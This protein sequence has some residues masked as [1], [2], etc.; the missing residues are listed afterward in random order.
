MGK[1]QSTGFRVTDRDLEIVRWLGRVRLASVEH[2]RLRFGM[3][4][5]KA[6]ER[7]A[8][9]VARGL[10]VRERHVPGHGVYV[11]TREGLRVAGLAMAPARVSL[12]ALAHDLACAEVVARIEAGLPAARLLTERQLRAHVHHTG[13]DSFR[14][15]VRQ[16]GRRDARHWP[17]L[18]LLTGSREPGWL[19]IEV[20]L[21]RKGARRLEAILD[22]YW[23]AAHHDTPHQVWGVL[24][25]VPDNNDRRRLAA[26]AER[27]GL[28]E[29]HSPVLFA[30]HT[31]DRHDEIA[32]TVLTLW[33]RKRTAD[34][35][36]RAEAAERERQQHELAA[37]QA[38]ERALTEDGIQRQRQRQEQLQA[39]EEAQR[40]AE[41]RGL[42]RWLGGGGR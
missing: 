35:R 17:D 4:R 21:H 29:Q 41:R 12:G 20:E 6:Y 7:L 36:H 33:K 40:R 34:A 32:A 10:V 24:Y 25:L 16:D 42:G 23:H 30:A 5:T 1:T 37:R 31:L 39:F 8:G 11:A 15:H 27:A 2:V 9:L 18:A 28:L 22:G 26:I 3:G 19:A 14:P 38:A 13:D